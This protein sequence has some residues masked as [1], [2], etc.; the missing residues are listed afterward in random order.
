[1]KK[2]QRNSKRIQDRLYTR[3]NTS[4]PSNQVIGMVNIKSPR[5]EAKRLTLR[6]WWKCQSAASL[7]QCISSPCLPSQHDLSRNGISLLCVLLSRGKLGFRLVIWH[8][9]YHT[10]GEHF[11]M[12]LHNLSWSALSKGSENNS[13]ILDLCGGL[14][15]SWP[16]NKRR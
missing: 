6:I 3:Q 14:S 12:S 11:C 4:S 10:W 15:V 2:M 13:Y 5:K 16:T 8:W 7:Y 9:S 1:M